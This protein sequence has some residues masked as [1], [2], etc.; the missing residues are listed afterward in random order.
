MKLS[1]SFIEGKLIYIIRELFKLTI[2]FIH[3]DFSSRGVGKV[4]DDLI[5]DGRVEDHV[6]IA[7]EFYS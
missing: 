4:F 2:V 5:I 6:Y 3:R 1:F 7:G